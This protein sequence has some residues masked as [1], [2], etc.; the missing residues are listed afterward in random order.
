MLYIQLAALIVMNNMYG[1]LQILKNV[2]ECTKV[3]LTP[4]RTDAELLA[5]SP[6][7]VRTHK[8]LVPSKKYRRLTK[9]V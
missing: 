7:N 6:I 8:I 1:L 3:I 2:S 5:I 4:N 9:L